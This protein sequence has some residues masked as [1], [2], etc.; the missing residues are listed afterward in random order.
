V[1]AHNSSLGAWLLTDPLA[2]QHQQRLDPVAA[3]GRV[4]HSQRQD[5]FDSTTSGGLVLRG[6]AVDRRQILQSCEAVRLKSRFHSWR[7]VRRRQLRATLSNS[8]A[9]SKP[10]SRCRAPS[11][12]PPA[13][14]PIS[15][16]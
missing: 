13:A 14:S 6:A 15:V 5:S 10:L 3:I 2:F 8:A 7:L 9:K 4:L 16:R 12:S 1:W 11:P